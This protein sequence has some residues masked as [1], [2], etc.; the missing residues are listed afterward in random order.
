MQAALD[1]LV[2][3]LQQHLPNPPKTLFIG[4][5][6]HPALPPL[7]GYQPLKPSFDSCKSSG[8]EMIEEITG[9]W[10]TIL[11]LPGKS[12]DETLAGFAKAHQHLSPQGT[13]IAALP[14]TAGAAR[15][16]K[17]LA[18]AS[19][20]LFS[21]SKKKCRAFAVSKGSNWSETLLSHWEAFG[22][23]KL[24][25][26]TP[27]IT[28]PGIFSSFRIDPGSALLAAH[29]PKSLHGQIADLGAGWGF[30]S[31]EALKKCPS[32]KEIAL[33]EADA[34]A[35]SC[36]RKNV[37][38]PASFHWHDVTTGLPGTYHHILINPPFHTGQSKDL[39]LGK[40]FLTT[41]AAALKPGG[42]IHLVANRQLPY[43][44][45]LQQLGLRSR[46]LFEDHTYKIITAS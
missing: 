17:E 9:T 44:A 31:F 37:T 24:I 36:A 21:V 25:D 23:R 8:M 35:L 45:H 6:P 34:R 16:E 33:F 39:D 12:K 26:N 27:F 2:L 10:D 41:A 20:L 11:F 19:P 14:N 7:H 38:G 5:A 29:L 40:A 42:T 22:A 4:A 43:E 30:L 18:K 3:A 13:F 28:E 32:I 46:Q 1:T 15:Y